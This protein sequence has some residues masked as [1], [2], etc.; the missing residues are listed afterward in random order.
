MSFNGIETY[1]EL[2]ARD[3]VERKQVEFPL[4][5]A[6]R[7]D[8]GELLLASP[9]HSHSHCCAS[10]EPYV[11]I[12][13]ILVDVEAE[14]GQLFPVPASKTS[15]PQRAPLAQK[16]SNSALSSSARSSSDVPAVRKPGDVATSS[17]RRPALQPSLS[18]PTTATRRLLANPA[19][20]KPLAPTSSLSRSTNTSGVASSSRRPL[21][22]STSARPTSSLSQSSSSAVPSAPRSRPG[23]LVS[24]TRKLSSSSLRQSASTSAVLGQKARE[25]EEEETKRREQFEAEERKLGAFG[26]VGDGELSLLDGVDAGLGDFASAF[27]E[28]GED[29]KLDLELE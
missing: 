27:G 15:A 5:E 21:A 7:A 8:S 19:V 4:E 10:P 23:S 22:A 12:R 1:E 9:C 24:T 20:R 25:Q 2:E 6:T 29:F 3:E 11:D 14:T 26:L 13:P 18:A 28:D 16:T 17:L